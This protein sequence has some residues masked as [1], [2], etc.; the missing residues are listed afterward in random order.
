MNIWHF[1]GRLGRDAELRTTQGGEKVLSFPVAND[2]GYG[3]NKTTQ[4]V[5]CSMW[6][7]RAEKLAALLK[8]GREVS[9][10]GE[11]TLREFERR[12]GSKDK[13]LTVRVSELDLHGGQGQGR[14]SDNSA[15]NSRSNGSVN[16]ARAAGEPDH[17]GGSDRQGAAG[18]PGGSDRKGRQDRSRSQSSAN[19]SQGSAAGDDGWDQIPF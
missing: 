15:G 13:A 12:D 1:N 2:I 3:E 9:I 17:Q 18:R 6:G 7:T 16:G 11:V 5:D 4:W 8:K 19:R 10:A 14:E